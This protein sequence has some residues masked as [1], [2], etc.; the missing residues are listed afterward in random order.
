MA[1]QVL[2]TGVPNANKKSCAD[3]KHCKALVNWWCKNKLAI[4]ARGT[5]IPGVVNCPFWE[6]CKTK[7][8]LSWSDRLFGDYIYVDPVE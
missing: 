2:E 8:E 7:K 6:G 5:K 4:K 3:C 1:E